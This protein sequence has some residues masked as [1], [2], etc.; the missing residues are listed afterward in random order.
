M[1][2]LVLSAEQQLDNILSEWS[3]WCDQRPEVVR[4]LIGGLTNQT[5]LLRS[6]DQRLVL[7]INAANSDALDL[8]RQSEVEVLKAA[9]D[10]GITAK[11]IY[12]DPK[13]RYM[14]TEF[15]IAAPWRQDYTSTNEGVEKLAALLRAIHTVDIVTPVLNNR[16]KAARYW[17]LIDHS[18][19]VAKQLSRISPQLEHAMQVASELN[20]VPCLC[21]NDLLAANLLLATNGQAYAIDWEYAATGDAYFDVAAVVEGHNLTSKNAG[22]L[23]LAYHLG[24]AAAVDLQRLHYARINFCY[25]D[26]LWYCA[27]YTAKPVM[28]GDI[29]LQKKLHYIKKLLA[30]ST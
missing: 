6:A 22:Q 21:H 18:S 8:N 16:Q 7:R 19:V 3:T 20:K 2:D 13:Y 26:L 1:I 23:L 4:P 15:I 28:A 9:A 30:E 11:L 10:A 12:S 29:F 25:L 5:Y 24:D 27:Q 14:L 17:Q